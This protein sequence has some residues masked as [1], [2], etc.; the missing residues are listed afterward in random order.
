MENNNE[1]EKIDERQQWRRQLENKTNNYFYY[2]IGWVCIKHIINIMKQTIREQEQN[3]GTH[4][5][6]R[7]WNGAAKMEERRSREKKSSPEPS[8]DGKETDGE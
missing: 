1:T 2:I 8:S 6:T 7:K 4:F 3:N 5:C